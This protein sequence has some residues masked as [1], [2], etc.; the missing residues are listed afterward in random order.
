M[1]NVKAD[2]GS[3]L[4]LRYDRLPTQ[5]SVS[6]QGQSATFDVIRRELLGAGM[7]VRDSNGAS[8]VIGLPQTSAF[9]RKLGWEPELQKL[10]PEGFRIRTIRNVV[11][12]ASTTDIG[13]LYGTFH[14]LRLLQTEQPI[15]R[16]QIDQ[17]PRLKLR[18]LNHWDN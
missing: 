13:T 5:V 17:R 2:D 10:G 8:V 16:L 7:V 9:I 12:I 6:V 3:R 15:D 14:F 18:L 1:A 4:W 11:V